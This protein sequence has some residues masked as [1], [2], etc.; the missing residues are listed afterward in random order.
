MV[1][2]SSASVFFADRLEESAELV[3]EVFLFVVEDGLS[4]SAF[5]RV[6]TAERFMH[7]AGEALGEVVQRPD[8]FVRVLLR[9]LKFLDGFGNLAGLEIERAH[10]KADGQVG[11]I[12][13]HPLLA[14]A[15]QKRK[16]VGIFIR[17]ARSAWSG[18]VGS[19]CAA[20]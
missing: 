7:A 16:L 13:H 9:L 12:A 2:C 17:A 15:D 18:S 4:L 8:A 10:L 3:D 11:G 14:F 1:N 5:W 6:R 20:R 19:S